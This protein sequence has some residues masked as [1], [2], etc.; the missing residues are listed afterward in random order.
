MTL[1]QNAPPAPLSAALA[2]QTLRA[3]VLSVPPLPIS[4]Q[5]YENLCHEGIKRQDDAKL[6]KI[7][8]TIEKGNCFYD[9]KLEVSKTNFSQFSSMPK[10]LLLPGGAQSA[11]SKVYLMQCR[12]LSVRK[13]KS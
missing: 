1:R 5:S 10:T 3:P 6:S 12:V 7:M 9:G 4:Y 11:R 2:A 8:V 13:T